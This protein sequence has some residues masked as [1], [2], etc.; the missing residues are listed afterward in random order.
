MWG[1]KERLYSREKYVYK[2]AHER[3]GHDHENTFE[4]TFSRKS[5]TVS[6]VDGRLVN[7]TKHTDDRFDKIGQQTLQVRANDTSTIN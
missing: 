3:R 6:R 2:V 4:Q 1:R 5:G 7:H